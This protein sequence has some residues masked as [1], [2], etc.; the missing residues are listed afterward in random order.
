MDPRDAR[1]QL[2]DRER[3]QTRDCAA[4]W[5]QFGEQVT[6]LH[7]TANSSARTVTAHNAGESIDKFTKTYAKFDGGGDDGYLASAAQAAHLLAN[8]LEACACLVEVA[9]WAVIAQLIALAIEI[10]AAH[11][12]APFTFGL[13]EVAAWAPC[14][15]PA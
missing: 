10:I 2:A 12:A 6:E 7:T 13:S 1:L 11:A 5:R 4:L 3:G 14:R 8:V 9:K 15:S